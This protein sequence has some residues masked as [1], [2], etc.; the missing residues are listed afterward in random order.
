MALN[1]AVYSWRLRDCSLFNSCIDSQRGANFCVIVSVTA[2][3]CQATWSDVTDTHKEFSTSWSYILPRV[4]ATRLPVPLLL[5]VTS[6]PV[7]TVLFVNQKPEL[8][9]NFLIVRC[10]RIFVFRVNGGGRNCLQRKVMRDESIAENDMKLSWLRKN[11]LT[12]E[13]WACLSCC[14]F[15]VYACP[16]IC[17]NLSRGVSDHARDCV[18]DLW[19]AAGL[20]T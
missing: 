6:D 9:L 8:K 14:V 11:A 17:T 1:E 18:P 3:S 13:H 2:L 16:M 7:P 20:R 19:S 12:A 10:N 5:S 15:S 4:I